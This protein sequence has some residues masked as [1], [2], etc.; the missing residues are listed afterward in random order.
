MLWHSQIK[1]FNI[2]CVLYRF[3]YTFAVL[4]HKYGT[5]TTL[6]TLIKNRRYTNEEV[7]KATGIH[8]NRFYIGLKNPEIFTDVEVRAISEA[9]GLPIK[10]INELKNK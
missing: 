4:K 1:Y 8:R 2:F 9:T 7:I 10:A 6:K 5:M 3:I